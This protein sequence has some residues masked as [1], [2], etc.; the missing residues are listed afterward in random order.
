MGFVLVGVVRIHTGVIYP[1]PP[2]TLQ[3]GVMESR[4]EGGFAMGD[5]GGHVL[6]IVAIDTARLLPIA[7][8]PPPPAR[9]GE[10][11]PEEPPS[12]AFTLSSLKYKWRDLFIHLFI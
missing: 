6:R 7:V 1:P 4:R 5:L 10:M 3:A 11:N 12:T 9:L 2:R 8:T